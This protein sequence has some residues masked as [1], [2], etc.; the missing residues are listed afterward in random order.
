MVKR[1]HSGRRDSSDVTAAV[2]T[3]LS[4]EEPDLRGE[5]DWRSY[6]ASGPLTDTADCIAKDL[7]SRLDAQ[8]VKV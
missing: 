3:R 2:L 7:M 1:E 8:G 4:R 5:D 6:D